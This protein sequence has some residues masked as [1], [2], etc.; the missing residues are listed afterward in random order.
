MTV[1]SLKHVWL[2]PGACIYTLSFAATWCLRLHLIIC[3]STSVRDFFLVFVITTWFQWLQQSICSVSG[4]NLMSK[5]TPMCL[6]IHL[7]AYGYTPV[8]CLLSMA[9]P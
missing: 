9:T 8:I 2:Y 6:W 1:V 5:I 3:I 4:Q 7:L